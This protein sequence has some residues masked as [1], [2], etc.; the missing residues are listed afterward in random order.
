[1]QCCR[2]GVLTIL[3]V[4]ARFVEVAE[5]RIAREVG[6]EDLGGFGVNGCEGREA[7]FRRGEEGV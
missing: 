5:R 1:M 6:G 7:L 2:F 3:Y 4:V